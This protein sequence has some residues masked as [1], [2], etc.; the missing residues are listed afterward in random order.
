MSPRHSQNTPG[1]HSDRTDFRL[2]RYGLVIF[3]SALLHLIFWRYRDLLNDPAETL[4]KPKPPIVVTLTATPNPAAEAPGTVPPASP[5]PARKPPST[6]PAKPKA[7]PV[8]R[9]PQPASPPKPAAKPQRPPEKPIEPAPKPSRRDRE[10]DPN[11][12]PVKPIEPPQQ[13]RPSPPADQVPASRPAT[14]TP[15]TSGPSPAT[16]ANRT[17]APATDSRAGGAYEGAKA[18]AAYLHNPKPEYPALA[19]RRQWEGKVILKVRVLADG[20]AT[21][22]SVATSSG[23]DL[24]DEAAIE[25]VSRW[26][27]VPAKQGGQSVDSWVNVPINFNLL[28]AQ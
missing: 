17:A 2:L 8:V 13:P 19:K 4:A 27:F 23:H 7:V 14:K 24:L 18:N 22:V 25:A 9:P 1:Q 16:T 10:E 12:P 20:K 3:L 28:N 21:Q 6:E 5:E 11:R 26:H 15:A